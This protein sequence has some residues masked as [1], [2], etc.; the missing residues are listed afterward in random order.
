VDEPSGTLRGCRVAGGL[1]GMSVLV[2]D[3]AVPLDDPEAHLAALARAEG[4]LRF[5]DVLLGDSEANRRIAAALGLGSWVGTP[6]VTQGRVVGVL[7]VDDHRDGEELEPADGPLLFTVGTLF[8]G[9]IESARLYAELAE[10]N[11]LLEARVAERTRELL[12]AMTEAQEA[13]SVAESANEAKSRF[14]SNISHELRTPLTSIVGFT[15]LN[16]R[17]LEETVFPLVPLE[18]PKV[19]RAVRQVG[20]TL[21][22]VVEEGDRLTGLI[23][24]LLDLAK[25][26]AGRLEWSMA[27]LA[28]GDVV[29]QALAATAALFEVSGLSLEIT[30]GPDLP[31]VTGDRNRLVQ[32]VINLISNAVKFTPE[33]SVRVAVH[34]A[35]DGV[36]VAVTDSG[37]GIAEG[38]LERI[39]EPFRQSSDTVPDGPK[40]TGLGL[41]ISRQIVEAHG[42]AMGVDSAIG[43]GSTFWFTIPGGVPDDRAMAGGIAADEAAP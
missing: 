2:A 5:R 17:R 30:E 26:E 8:A 34:G 41:P 35:G 39:F 40:G 3:L 20:E 13:R 6:L 7:V 42:G 25:I 10:Q 32:V 24:D 36:R 21:A 31:L 18:E 11:R 14:L 16:R 22:I 43:R 12:E 27:P 37:R 23:N 29:R 4:P 28:L 33:G 9:A 38:D 19:A 1:P 15:R